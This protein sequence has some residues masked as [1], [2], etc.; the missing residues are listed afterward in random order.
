MLVGKTTFGNYVVD[1]GYRDAFCEYFAPDGTVTRVELIGESRE[2]RTGTYSLED[3]Q[4]CVSYR[5]APQCWQVEAQQS[6]AASHVW[7]GDFYTADGAV[8][9][10]VVTA[11]GN[12]VDRCH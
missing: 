4:V 11:E 6:S 7:G 2:I 3:D 12:Q 8:E 10:H 5:G 1:G 9:S